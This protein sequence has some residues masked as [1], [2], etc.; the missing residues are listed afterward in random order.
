MN[1]LF[2]ALAAAGIALSTAAAAQPAATDLAQR[3]PLLLNEA[4]S[5]VPSTSEVGTISTTLSA[6]EWY[7]SRGDR[8]Q[9]VSY[10][11]FAR[12]RLGLSLVPPA[13]PA[14]PATP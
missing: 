9:A 12:G 4:R 2:P 8:A 13:A 6:A 11:N 14:G 10:L 3:F 7:W 5:K 1:T